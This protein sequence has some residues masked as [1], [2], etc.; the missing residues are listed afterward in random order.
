[1]AVFGVIAGRKVKKE[2]EMGWTGFKPGGPAIFAG[3]QVNINVDESSGWVHYLVAPTD[4]PDPR[5]NHIHVKCSIR[6]AEYVVAAVKVN[7]IREINRRK[8]VEAINRE[9]GLNI[10]Y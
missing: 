4:E 1:L 6:T 2:D 9:T 7:G 8:L 3:F 10:R 5:N